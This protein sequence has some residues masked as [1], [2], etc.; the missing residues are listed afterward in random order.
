MSCRFPLTKNASVADTGLYPISAAPDDVWCAFQA[1]QQGQSLSKVQ[2]RVADYRTLPQISQKL[3]GLRCGLPG[4]QIH[5]GGAGL[6]AP[7]E[8][9][10]AARPPAREGELAL[11]IGLAQHRVRLA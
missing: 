9:S 2:R 3:G 6:Y 1:V 8:T 11:C 4:S 5:W 10:G 7:N